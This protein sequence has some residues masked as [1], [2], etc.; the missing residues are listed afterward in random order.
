[1]AAV[2]AAFGLVDIYAFPNP[3]RG[4]HSATI[5]V[6]VGLAD[7]VDV[8]IYDVAGRQVNSGSV[9]SPSILDDNNGKVPQYTFDYVWDTS[10]VGSGVYVYAVTAKKAGA[11]PIRKQGKVGVIR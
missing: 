6:Q 9:L 10:G 1:M 4:G 7:S 3:A 11:G 2:S 8:D 5:R